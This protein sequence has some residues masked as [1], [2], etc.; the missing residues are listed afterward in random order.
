MFRDLLVHVDGSEAGRRRVCFAVDL[1]AR[2]GARLSGLHETPP[3]EVPPLYKPSMV[4]K[5]AA[6][7]ASDLATD[8]RVAAK[9]FR[10]ETRQRRA[11]ARW[12]EAAGD[13][14]REIC[15]KA[16]YADLVILGQYERQGA[17]EAHPL[18]V[19]HP[20]V[21]RCG[22]PVPIA[23]ADV[24]PSALARIAVAWDGSREAARAVHDALPLLCLSQSVQI[25]EVRHSS[26]E[27]DDIDCKSLSAH[28]GDHGI[29]VDTHNRKADPSMSTH[30]SEG[31]S[32]RGIMIWW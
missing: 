18:P 3:P 31:R 5:V 29:Q 24:R 7:I 19:A 15:A 21:V 30:R 10:E 1:A 16:G 2:M 11:D 13:V 22:R 12:F 14:V 25:V 17:P 32:R 23:L 28:L 20:V 4:T 26:G 8:A 9:I 6:D 27:D